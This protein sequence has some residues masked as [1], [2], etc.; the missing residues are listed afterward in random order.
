MNHSSTVEGGRSLGSQFYRGANPQRLKPMQN[1]FHIRFAGQLRSFD[2][3]WEEPV[4]A[5]ERLPNLAIAEP[6][7]VPTRVHR[8][9]PDALAQRSQGGG[10]ARSR[11][12]QMIRRWKIR[13]GGCEIDIRSG[14]REE[15]PLVRHR[16]RHRRAGRLRRMFAQAADDTQ[17]RQSLPHPRILAY[18]T[19]EHCVPAEPCQSGSRMRRAAA[20]FPHKRGGVRFLTARRPRFKTGKNLIK[21]NFAR[22][23]DA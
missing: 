13:E 1:R 21:V 16:N 2:F 18:R 3:V 4:H 5:R 8:Y 9:C 15:S 6:P 12:V 10:R 7:R 14:I 22:D 20:E 11:Q 17:F 19:N 23:Y